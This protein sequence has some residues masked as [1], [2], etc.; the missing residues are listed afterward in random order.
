[1]Y[2]DPLHSLLEEGVHACLADEQVRPLD[3]HDAG[4]ET[5]VT[6]ILQLFPLVVALGHGQR[7]N[8]EALHCTLLWLRLAV[9]EGKIF[10]LDQTPYNASVTYAVTFVR[11][12]LA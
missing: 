3:H 5:G 4:K 8:R 11:S 9:W 12:T 6:G 7:N 10:S 1:M 2:W